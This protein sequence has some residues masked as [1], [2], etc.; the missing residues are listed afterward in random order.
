[1][2]LLP[3]VLRERKKELKVLEKNLGV[4]FRKIQYLQW[5][6]Q[7][8]SYVNEFADK[9]LINN[10][11]LEF[12]GDSILG[13]FIAHYLFE[14]YP[15]YSEGKMSILK[16]SLVN[17]EILA[18]LA[19]KIDLGSYLLLGKGEEKAGGRERSSIL[20]DALEAVI[21]SYYLDRGFKPFYKFL[22]LFYSELIEETVSVG[23]S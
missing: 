2:P 7:H 1:M 5:A 4:R 9:K 23:T 3:G 8:R 13:H 11:Q 18:K 21:A 15:H 16:S 6:L 14:K 10:E 19:I 12:L 17:Q 22:T 20:A